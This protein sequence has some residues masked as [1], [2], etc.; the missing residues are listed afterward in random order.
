MNTVPLV[1]IVIP[2]HNHAGYL[3][4]AIQS[5]LRQDYTNIELIVLDD[6]STDNTKQVLE[7]YNGMFFWESQ[8]NKGQASTLNKGWQ[9]SKGEILSYLSA[10]DH[11]LPG[12]VSTAV[13]YLKEN[14][15]SV[16]AYC[17]FNLIA[18]DSSIVRRVRAPDFSFY[19]MAV[20]LVCAPGPG[21]FFWRTAFE[22]AGLWNSSYKQM[23]DFEYWLRLGLVGNFVRIPQVLALFR[24]H[25]ESQT[26]SETDECRAEEPIRIISDFFRNTDLPRDIAAEEQKA[27]S[28]AYLVS[29]QLDFRAGRYGVGYAKLKR[30]FSIYWQNLIAVSTL[31]LILNGLFNRLG[32]ELYW[33][34][35][36]LLTKKN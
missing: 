29:A 15:D 1:S 14:P 34:I 16:L 18:P 25:H 32:H 22:S 10:D 8:Q 11:L 3:D 7:K 26:Y 21:V 12:A 17:D 35:A 5:V 9:M 20:N 13:K 30:A 19:D 27:L 24:V 6:G 36:S 31:R 33:K 4:S 23:P 2:A 28:N